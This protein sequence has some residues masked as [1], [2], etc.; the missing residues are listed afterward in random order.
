MQVVSKKFYIYHLPRVLTEMLSFAP[1]FLTPPWFKKVKSLYDQPK[2]LNLLYRGTEQ[3]FNAEKFHQLCDNKG[4]TLTIC[5]S[6][7]DY[8]F[9]LSTTVPWQRNDNWVTNTG[10]SFVFRVENADKLV[11]ARL[12]DLKTEA[13]LHSPSRLPSFDSFQLYDKAHQNDNWT[14]VDYEYYNIPED[15]KIDLKTY[16]GGAELFKLVE[17][18]VY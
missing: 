11:K 15:A 7:H 8:I 6:E 3:E 18:E 16:W 10:E 17:L 13:I 14:S 9:G 12:K 4:P 2:Q 1:S 5:K